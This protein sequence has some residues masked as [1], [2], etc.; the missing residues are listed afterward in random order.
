MLKAVMESYEATIKRLKFR[1]QEL[2][3]VGMHVGIETERVVSS[4]AVHSAL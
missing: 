3:E 2:L 1:L 4:L